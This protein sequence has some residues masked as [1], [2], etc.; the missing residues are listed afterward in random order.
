MVGFQ[1]LRCLWKRL[2][3]TLQYIMSK[4][5]KFQN[6]TKKDPLKFLK[7]AFANFRRNFA[8]SRGK[9]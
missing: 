6:L 5:L 2:D 8:L 7:I 4:I 1:S 3:E 9:I